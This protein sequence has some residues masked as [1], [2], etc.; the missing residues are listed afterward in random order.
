MGGDV[1]IHMGSKKEGT[2]CGR[3]VLKLFTR[4]C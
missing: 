2:I 1:L 4:L 3:C